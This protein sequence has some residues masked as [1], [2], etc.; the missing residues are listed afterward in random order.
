MSCGVARRRTPNVYIVGADGGPT[1]HLLGAHAGEEGVMSPEG[2]LSGLWEAPI[3]TLER[4]PVRMDGAVLRAVKTQIME[5]TL[6]VW[7]S[8]KYVSTG[9]LDPDFAVLD[10]EFREAFSFELDPYYPDSAL[11]R[12]VW[13]DV[14][15]LRWVEVCLASANPKFEVV[16]Q[17]RGWWEVELKLKAYNPFWQEEPDIVPVTFSGTGSHTITVSNPGA[18]PGYLK[19]V[20]TRAQYQLP[21][22]TWAGRKFEREPG[23]LY[24]A[25]T[26]LYPPL[27][28]SN[29]GIVVD[30]TP[31]RIPV[32]DGADT[33][34]I[35]QMPVPGDYPKYPLPPHTQEVE[36]T[37]QAVAV[38]TGSA[39]LMVVQQRQFRRPWGRV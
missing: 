35:A 29:G 4:S 37:V 1:F 22:N 23:G 31:G 5:I 6:T 26:L 36:L 21:D 25:R 19:Y 10:G 17:N 9:M 39:T 14:D 13:D 12:I 20:G 8:D 15:S 24:P 38:P 11:A 3:V 30:Y 2:G 34:L 33:N 28:P 16:P 18:V 32:R 7:V 27:G